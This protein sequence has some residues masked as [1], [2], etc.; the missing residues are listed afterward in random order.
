L[1]RDRRHR[2]RRVVGVGAM[3]RLALLLAL[4]PTL[5][6]ADGFFGGG[7]GGVGGTGD[8]EAVWGCTGGDCSA[9]TAAS[10]DTLNAA[11]ADSSVPWKVDTSDPGTCTE[12]QAFYN[13]TDNVPKV[14]TAANTLSP[15]PVVEGV[16]VD[17]C[18]LTASG[19]VG[20]STCSG[21]VCDSAGECTFGDAA[22]PGRIK[23]PKGDCSS[24]PTA[25]RA[26]LC[27]DTTDDLVVS[28]NGG[29]NVK[30]PYVA[31]G[32]LSS[33]EVATMVSGE[34][35][36]GALCFATSPTL[37]TPTISGA[38]TLPDDVRQTFN[39]GSTVSGL[40]VGELAGDPSTPVDGDLWYDGTAEELTARINGSNVAL[41]AGGSGGEFTDEGTVL[42]PSDAADDWIRVSGDTNAAAIGSTTGTDIAFD[43]GGGASPA[44]DL[45]CS[46]S[47][48]IIA[49][50]RSA[51]GTVVHNFTNSGA[52]SVAI[53]F[54][55]GSASSPNIQSATTTDTG[56]YFTG[57]TTAMRFAAA[58][59]D[60]LVFLTN[61]IQGRND[62]DITWSNNTNPVNID[63]GITRAAAAELKI[64]AGL[65]GA[66]R[67]TESYIELHKTLSTAP[68]EP[69]A[70]N[71]ANAGTI[72]YV[73][74]TDDS[75]AAVVCVCLAT[76]DD[77]AGTP[78]GFDW[79]RM[80]DNA[81]ACP[82]I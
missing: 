7:G 6:L 55:D 46:I 5:A 23:F 77:G 41:G 35:G 62:M 16:I 82:E 43:F 76:S 80:D 22:D 69:F 70:C 75:A 50:N 28:I 59:A 61:D 66:G 54:E 47:G 53:R 34:T 33:A 71:A 39:P 42:R 14:C 15:I 73:D 4:L 12:N 81:T 48:D 38:I 63:T 51:S 40:N 30:L 45:T 79:M 60:R 24:V 21:V 49:W 29:S 13:S 9:L 58:G 8:V 19:S 2:D 74:D 25:S 31:A 3:R 10:G 36:S 64:Q 17:T 32:R 52:G 11:S 37:T 56:L 18:V 72:E 44:A 27:H 1:P 57:G 78:S 67:L 68:T 65:S 26:T 20:P